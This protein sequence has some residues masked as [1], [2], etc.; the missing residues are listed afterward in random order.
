MSKINAEESRKKIISEL[1]KTAEQIKETKKMI[2]GAYGSSG[3]Y[4]LPYPIDSV[5][6]LLHQDE[7]LRIRYNVLTDI[8]ELLFGEEYVG[9]EE[10][11]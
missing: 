6:T 8:Y 5:R 9:R 4:F 1:E 2:S 10:K 7:C 11:S 3:L